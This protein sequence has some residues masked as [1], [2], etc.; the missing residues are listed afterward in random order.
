MVKDGRR[1]RIDSCCEIFSSFAI[2]PTS[3]AAEDGEE[4]EE[5]CGG[6]FSVGD[7]DGVVD[8]RSWEKGTVI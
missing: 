8:R 3:T 4:V 1:G 2:A 5:G 7:A 6:F